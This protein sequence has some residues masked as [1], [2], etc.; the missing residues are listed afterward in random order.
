MPPADS[1][2]PHANIR[3][4]KN[5]CGYS[6]HSAHAWTNAGHRAADRI[7]GQMPA[8]PV[9]GFGHNANVL[10]GWRGSGF[11]KNRL[12]YLLQAVA[13]RDLWSVRKQCSGLGEVVSQTFVGLHVRHPVF[14]RSRGSQVWPDTMCDRAYD[15]S[16]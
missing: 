15:P 5:H 9:P 16:I 4:S 12:Y 3:S 10:A 11:F 8:G 1:S 6:M 13:E 2:C 14:I 7:N